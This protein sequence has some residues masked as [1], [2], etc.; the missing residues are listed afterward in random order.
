M[1]K[2]IHKLCEDHLLSYILLQNINISCDDIIRIKV[3]QFSQEG[4]NNYKNEDKPI[5]ASILD[6][7]KSE[8][9]K[10]FPP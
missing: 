1:V 3:T 10:N 9:S 5:L 6:V 2:T 4:E 8:R 7:I